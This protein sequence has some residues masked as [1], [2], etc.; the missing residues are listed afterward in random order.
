MS[1]GSQQM[2]KSDGQLVTVVIPTHNRKGLLKRALHSVLNQ[3]YLPL[4]IIVINDGSTDDTETYVTELQQQYL[5]IKYLKHPSPKGAPKARNYGIREA[6]GEFITFLDDDDEL[7]P[8]NIKF[9]MQHYSD[10]YAYICTGQTRINS[11][12]SIDV[13]PNSIIT[14]NDMLYKITTGNQILTRRERVMS[15]GGF[16]E[17]LLSSQDYDMWLRL[18]EKYGDAKCI[19]KPLIIVHTEHDSERITS[20]PNRINGALTFYKKHQSK[21]NRRQKKYQQFYLLKVQNKRV[22][23]LQFLSL[24]P[25]EYYWPDIKYCIL[26]NYPRLT[27]AKSKV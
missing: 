3:S 13:L 4:E 2:T 21:M 22:G 1:I 16:D 11:Q 23:L 5:Q 17:T 19:R 20:S 12:R 8:D 7:H 15:L 9:C 25:V 24:V 18:N 14:Y 26:S 6:S 10:D 27:R